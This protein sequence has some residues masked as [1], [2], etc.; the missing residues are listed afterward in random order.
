MPIPPHAR[1]R[2]VS[3]LCLDL[4][5]IYQPFLFFAGDS[6]T[7]KVFKIPQDGKVTGAERGVGG[8]EKG[9]ETQGGQPEWASSSAQMARTGSGGFSCY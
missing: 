7:E 4:P 3:P 2:V 9:A 8:A 5:L 1:A 6:Y